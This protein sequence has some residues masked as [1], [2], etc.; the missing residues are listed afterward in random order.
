MKLLL[1]NVSEQRA[2]FFIQN[3]T[4]FRLV[5]LELFVI[6]MKLFKTTCKSK[7]NYTKIFKV[8]FILYF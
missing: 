7:Y 4:G 5:C 1:I 3:L 2:R 8:F 6:K